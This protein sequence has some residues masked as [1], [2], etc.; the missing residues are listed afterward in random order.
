MKVIA[1]APPQ[2]TPFEPVRVAGP[3]PWLTVLLTVACGLIAANIYYAQPLAGPLSAAL[4]MSPA[5]AGLVVTT[6]QAGYGLG[7]LLIVPLGDLVENRGLVVAILAVAVLALLGAGLATGPGAFLLASLLVG[8]GSVAVQ[9]LVPYAAHLA[10]EAVR[11]RVVGNV[12]GGLMAGIMLARPIAS[13]VAGASA[14]KVV[15]L[16]SAG[17]MAVLAV[18]LRLALPA[19]RPPAGLRYGTLLLSMGRLLLHTPVLRRR[20][21]YHACLFAS[22]SLFWTVAPLLLADRFRLSQNGIALFAAVGMAGV[23]AAPIAGRVADRGW[24]RRATG[25]AMVMVLLALLLSLLGASG[26]SLGLLVLALAAILLDFGVTANGVLGQR[27][28][29]ALPPAVHG[30]LNGLYMA[31]FFAGGALGSAVGGWSYAEGSWTLA[32]T[33]GLALVLAGLACFATEPKETR[34]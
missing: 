21:F 32:V 12:M 17:L 29:Y 3:T 2:A 31:T 30:R 26:S 6:T 19:R 8:V 34:A 14:P 22:F 4:G 5:A 11:G 25:L 23:L 13:L 10:Q 18:V 1:P 27:A 20:A 9:V 15:F 33:V 28:I 7:L 24:T 16:L